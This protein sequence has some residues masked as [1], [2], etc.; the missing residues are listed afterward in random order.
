MIA[1]ENSTSPVEPEKKHFTGGAPRSA[2]ERSSEL[3]DPT[4]PVR[5]K[6]T[7]LLYEALTSSS[8]DQQ[9]KADMWHNFARDILTLYLKNLKKY[10][11]CVRSKVTNL[12]NPPKIL[13]TN[14]AFW[15]HVAKRIC[16]NDC[17][18]NGTRG[19]EAVESCIHGIS[20]PGT[21]VSPSGGGHTDKIKCRS[22]KIKCRSCEK[23]N[24]KVTVITRGA[25]FLPGWVRN[26]N[27]D[28]D[29][30][31]SV[32]CNECGEQWYHSRWVC[33]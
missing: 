25:L 20:H 26:S 3:P 32:I 13:T 9:P 24:C 4:V 28:E 18:G 22:Y 11:T 12:K 23:F 2:D 10:K 15:D 14:L 31:T 29:T 7:E 8:T 27:P 33:L 21:P 1:P 19:P 6:G 17:P 16:Q 30:M 5:A